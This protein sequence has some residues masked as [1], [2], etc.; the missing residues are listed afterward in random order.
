MKSFK[1]NIKVEKYHLLEMR[2]EIEG[3][4]KEKKNRRHGG[5]Y[6]EGY[7]ITISWR[8]RSLKCFY[9]SLLL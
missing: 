3:I 4:M 1:A 5:Y 9:Y 6:A 2:R 8:S 7:V